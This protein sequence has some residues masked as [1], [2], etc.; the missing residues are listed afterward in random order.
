MMQNY[1]INNNF[2]KAKSIN[3]DLDQFVIYY[4]F[5]LVYDDYDKIETVD[6]SVGKN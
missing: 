4:F 5:E 2:S 1:H 6:I 3:R